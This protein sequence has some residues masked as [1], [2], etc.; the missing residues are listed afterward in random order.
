MASWLLCGT[1]GCIMFNLALGVSPGGQTTPVL[2]ELAEGALPT[3]G[4]LV[5]TSMPG[6]HL[7]IFSRLGV[8]MVLTVFRLGLTHL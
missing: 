2:H 6:V 4:P 3:A 5:A 1:V 7:M 8:S